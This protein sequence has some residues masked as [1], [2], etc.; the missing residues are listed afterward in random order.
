MMHTL[1]LRA[2]TKLNERRTPLIPA[3]ARILVKNGYRVCVEASRD[4][5]F[6][7]SA[8]RKQGCILVEKGS[9]RFAS[10][11]TLIL[12]LKELPEASFPLRHR[13]F[14]FAHAYERQTGSVDLLE[15][16]KSGGGFLYD[17]E[18]IKDPSGAQLVT[19]GAG[20]LAGLCAATACL[21]IWK[22]RQCE[23]TGAYRV[24]LQ[25]ASC[26]E[27]V[28]YARSLVTAHVPIPRILVVGH[29]G[30]S[31]S[32]VAHLLDEVGLGFDRSPKITNDYIQRRA[33]LHQY[34]II[35][36]C[37]KLSKDTPIFLSKDMINADT[38][39]ALIGDV[40]CEPTH[41]DNPIPIYSAPTNF[42]QP[43]FRTPEGID[44]M[45]IDNI[46]AMLPV[47]C[48]QILSEQIFP[49]LC[50]FLLAQGVH[51]ASPFVRVVDSFNLA[52]RES[53]GRGSDD[54]SA[55]SADRPARAAK[56]PTR[57]ASASFG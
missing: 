31:G 45:A 52:C 35:F 4:R 28:A 44:V 33:L 13:H 51:E 23:R 48:S 7:N 15:R 14:Y 43:V 21:D 3:H 24:P 1:W 27:L 39:I 18:Q 9:W 53:L 47:E 16:F 38:R 40:S 12:G 57:H 34:D 20:Y 10:R 19:G 26:A 46:T 49:Y 29:R 8:Y 54:V 11:D 22:Q 30:K 37:I 36:N 17:L 56:L 32:G 42:A 41:P 6:S 25:F 50:Y 2:E 55:G 5:I